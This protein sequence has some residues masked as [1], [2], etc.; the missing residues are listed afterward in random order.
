MQTLTMKTQ[1][2]VEAEVSGGLSRI[3]LNSFGRGPRSIRT[4]MIPLGVVVVIENILTKPEAI[5]MLCESSSNLFR[6]MRDSMLE[7][8]RSNI[9]HMV[10]DAT[11][12][13]VNNMHHKIANDGEESFV[14]S[15]K[16]Q[17]EYRVRRA[18]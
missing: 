8:Y 11:G 10:E 5:L 1:G 9:F 14:F 18:V 15:L 6:S 16:S 2:E 17:P 3:L 13:E 4:T 7:A 12:S